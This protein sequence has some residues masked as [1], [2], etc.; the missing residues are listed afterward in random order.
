M[1]TYLK[2]A[3][4]AVL[5]GGLFAYF[6]YRD[7]KSEVS[8]LTNSHNELYLFQVGVFKNEI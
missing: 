8:A 1:K 6:F 5:V 3:V 4:G 2:L 7:I